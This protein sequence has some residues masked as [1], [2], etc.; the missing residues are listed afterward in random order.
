VDR[1]LVEVEW[2][3]PLVIFRAFIPWFEIR[4]LRI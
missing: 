4:M 2:P 1:T 3:N